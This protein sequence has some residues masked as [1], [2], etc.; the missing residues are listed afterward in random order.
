MTRHGQSYQ[1]RENIDA[2]NEAGRTLAGGGKGLGS[3]CRW[4]DQQ[5]DPRTML[6]IR[7]LAPLV[8]VSELVL[9]TQHSESTLYGCITAVHF[10]KLNSHHG[11]PRILRLS[12]RKDLL[13]WPRRELDQHSRP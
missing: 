12:H 9:H 3:A 10:L 8:V 13:P 4:L 6:K 11:R 7:Y 5:R 2:L 1:A